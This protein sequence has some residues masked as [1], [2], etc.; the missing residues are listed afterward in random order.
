MSNESR[1]DIARRMLL[2]APPGQLER[3]IQD[4][5]VI[6]AASG[7]NETLDDAWLQQVR[8]EHRAAVTNESDVP[9]QCKELYDDM[10][11]YQAEYYSSK[12]VV[13]ALSVTQQ[14]ANNTLVETYAERLDE[15]NQQ[16]GSWTATWTVS[17]STGQVK[18]TVNVNAL[19]YEVGTIQL[20]STRYFGPA[21]ASS[22]GSVVK[23]I[24]EWEQTCVDSIAEQYNNMGEKLKS[25]RRVMPVTRTKM[26]WNVLSHRMVKLLD[27]S[28]N[29]NA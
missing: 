8:A 9:P 20:H 6:F 7:A 3:L 10:K 14:D 27:D 19:C 21:Q 16:A 15:S 13:S 12:G 22:N 17:A 24:S 2:N 23:Q 4:F 5:K 11:K 18:G 28:K 29:T 26:E 1:R 25:L